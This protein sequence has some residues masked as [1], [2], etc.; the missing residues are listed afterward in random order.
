MTMFARFACIALLVACGGKS[1]PKTT[2]TDHDDHAMAGSGSAEPAA[3]HHTDHDHG[4]AGSGSASATEPAK[5]AEPDP[6]QVR[7]ELLAAENAAFEKA[8]PV[9][10]KF[11]AKCHSKSGSKQSQKKRDHFDMTTYP[12][13]GHHAETI[14]SEVRKSLAIGGG[15]PTMPADNKG[16]VK[17]DDL[18]AIAVWADAFEK[19][20]AGG[21][22]EG[23][24][25]EHGHDAHKH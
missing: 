16:A 8:K 20:H 25:H 13:G 24:G 23:M 11:C 17:G 21:A 4:M 14:A 15:K 22:H 19:A 7:A 6:A 1:A 12:F 18:A 2:S 9:F 10:D 5:P 3:H